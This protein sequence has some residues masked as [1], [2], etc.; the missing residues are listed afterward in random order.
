MLYKPV[1]E[2]FKNDFRCIKEVKL[3]NRKIDLLL[4]GKNKNSPRIAIEFKLKD[5]KKAIQQVLSYQLIADYVYIA[6]YLKN[7][8]LVDTNLVKMYGIGL[9]VANSRR[10]EIRIEPKKNN[11]FDQ[12]L[13][14]K[15]RTQHLS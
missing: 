4:I 7:E 2:N 9:I 11:I 15:I 12:K 3:Y 1:I 14:E 10:F 13:W 6:L 8:T 5:W